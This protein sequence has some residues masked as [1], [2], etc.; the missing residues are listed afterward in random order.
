M[1]SEAANTGVKL[2]FE[3]Q[4][5]WKLDDILGS[6]PSLEQKA[7]SPTP[8]MKAKMKNISSCKQLHEL[9]Y[10]VQNKWVNRVRQRKVTP[11][12]RRLDINCNRAKKHKS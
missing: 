5:G 4:K 3:A 2:M 1:L 11:A 7:Y 12:K 9:T 8:A 6:E 10:S